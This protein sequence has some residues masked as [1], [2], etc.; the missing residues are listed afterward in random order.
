MTP[1]RQVERLKASA[2]YGRPTPGWVVLVNGQPTH[3]TGP[4]AAK[5]SRER[6]ARAAS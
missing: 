6:E 1:G 4:T 2:Y 3:Y 5:D